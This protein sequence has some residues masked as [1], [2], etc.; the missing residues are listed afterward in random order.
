MEEMR[1]LCKML[2]PLEEGVQNELKLAAATVGTEEYNTHMK[3]VSE[4]LRLMADHSDVYIKIYRAN[5][6]KKNRRFEVVKL[7]VDAGVRL[8]T[9][10]LTCAFWMTRIRE[11]YEYEDSNRMPTSRTFRDVL[12]WMKP[13][14]VG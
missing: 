9:T 4:L 7:S 8:I 2:A 12:S 1:E 10:V 11:G 3:N 5:D 6:E 14:S 13:K